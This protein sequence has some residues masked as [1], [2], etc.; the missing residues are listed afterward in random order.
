MKNKFI[1]LAIIL[2]TGL[3]TTMFA[4]KNRTLSKGF[5]VNLIIGVPSAAYGLT[6]DK[7]I[8][9][10]SVSEEYKFGSVWGVQ[11]G[12]RWYFSPTKNYGFGL[13]VNWADISFAVKAGTDT[14]GDWAR[15][16]IDFSFLEVGPVG[17]FALTDKLALDAYYNLR[18]TVFSNAWVWSYSSGGSAD[19]TYAYVGVGVSHAIGAALRYKIFNIGMEYTMGAINS[20]GSYSGSSDNVTLDDQ[21]NVVNCFRIKLGLKL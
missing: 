17:T 20:S 12:N 14:D 16:A 10:N 1:L 19:E 8:D 11:I 4:Q 3:T 21:K 15:A 7:K 9:G 5:S 2:I 6:S 13:M 18:P